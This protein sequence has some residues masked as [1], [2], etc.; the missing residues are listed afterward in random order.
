MRSNG[1]IDI[2]GRIESTKNYFILHNFWPIL[3]FLQ[4]LGLFPCKKVT[5]ENGLIRLQPMKT[6]FSITLFFTW[7]LILAS[8]P[9]GI[10]CVKEQ[11]SFERRSQAPLL[12]T[13]KSDV[14]VPLFFF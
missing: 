14:G 5:D 2:P 9:I 1:T 10:Q 12:F 3:K 13:K 11:H 8:P 4:V 7:T 6:W